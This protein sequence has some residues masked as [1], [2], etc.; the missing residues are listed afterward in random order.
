MVIEKRNIPNGVVF[1]N[2]KVQPF[3]GGILRLAVL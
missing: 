2:Q 1:G 3:Q